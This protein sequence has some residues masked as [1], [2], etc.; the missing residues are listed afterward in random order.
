MLNVCRESGHCLLAEVSK[1]LK[2]VSQQLGL[3]VFDV[4]TVGMAIADLLGAKRTGNRRAVYLKSLEHYLRRFAA[5]RELTPIASVTAVEIE[6]WLAKFPLPYSRQTW[7]NRISTL[8]SYAVRRGHCDKNPCDRIERVTIDRKPPK[9]VS[10][11]EAKT[12]LDSVKSVCRPYLILA[13]FAGIRPDE[14][15]RLDWSAVDLVTGTVKVDGKTRRRR[16]VTLEPGAVALLAACPLKSGP[17]APS[18]GVVRSFKRAARAV[19]GWKTWHKD[20]LRHTA[21]SYL[22]ALHKDAAKVALSLGNSVAVLMSHYME[23]VSA[24]NAAAF[25]ALGGMTKT[26]QAILEPTGATA[27]ALPSGQINRT[28][29][30]ES[31]GGTESPIAGSLQA[32]QPQ[33]QQSGHCGV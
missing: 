10:P 2:P 26:D 9:I 15:M 4:Q 29:Q 17:V 6:K 8:F 21:A 23:P 16:I 12:L 27:R 19:L 31:D 24:E 13:M 1:Q 25:W 28:H 22:L 5:G 32:G 20:V 11:A 3:A 33:R 30:P 14:L 18:V 7:L